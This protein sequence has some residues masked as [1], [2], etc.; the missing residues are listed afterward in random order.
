[1]QITTQVSLLRQASNRQ[2]TVEHARAKNRRSR[3]VQSRQSASLVFHD[4]D[5]EQL[6][7]A[8]LVWDALVDQVITLPL[9]G[10]NG[11]ESL[12]RRFE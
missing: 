10:L 1:M 3:R 9:F 5:L 12:H 7:E 6:A 2:M 8:P 4:R 11:S